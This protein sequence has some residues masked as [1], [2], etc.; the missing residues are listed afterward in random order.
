MIRTA[1]PAR[2]HP[3]NVPR[4]GFL[5]LLGIL[6]GLTGARASAE[7]GGPTPSNLA[8]SDDGSRV[9]WEM[10]AIDTAAANSRARVYL[11]EPDE[12]LPDRIRRV[13]T[14]ESLTGFA[15]RALTRRDEDA[16][17]PAFL[18]GDG[19]VSFLAARGASARVQVWV[20]S[21]RG[22]EAEPWTSAAADVQTYAWAPDGTLFYIV[23]DEL[24][25]VAGGEPA[26]R[27]EA[28]PAARELAISF[29]GSRVAVPGTEALWIL[30]VATGEAR[31]V[32]TAPWHPSAPRWAESG[33]EVYF[34]AGA[35]SSDARSP[36]S[37]FALDLKEG[38]V[39]HV[40]PRVEGEVLEL[41]SCPRSDKLFVR[42]RE[43]A[44]EP[45]YRLHPGSRKA[46]ELF[47]E[48][49][50]VR[51]I[52]VKSN[53]E[54]VAFVWRSETSG[55]EIATWTFPD[56]HIEVLTTLQTESAPEE[57]VPDDSKEQNDG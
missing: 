55:P 25:R 53:G 48:T 40:A 26:E 46:F 42:V 8:I 29:D 10:A 6:A 4:G 45:L 21:L 18:P 2:R 20:L 50:S 14:G 51:D 7:G 43:G 37:V 24:W 1:P 22:G 28:V 3:R 41:E 12:S 44:N 16:R 47:E 9:L 52:S 30:D 31:V 13:F 49:G 32:D 39:T 23:G 11:W 38:G 17:V 33:D 54:K 35:D 34:L 56:D 15:P 57:D 5:A 36:A 19:A 27:C